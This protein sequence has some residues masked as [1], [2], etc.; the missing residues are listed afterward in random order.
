MSVDNVATSHSFGAYNET[1]S[2]G[3]A[4][5]VLAICCRMYKFT[6]TVQVMYVRCVQAQTEAGLLSKG[7]YVQP[8]HVNSEGVIAPESNTQCSNLLPNP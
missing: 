5:W 4:A 8:S 1:D 3:Q 7:S 2:T 6:M